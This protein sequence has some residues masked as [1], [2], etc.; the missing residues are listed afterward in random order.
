MRVDGRGWVKPE[1]Y[2]FVMVEAG[3]GVKLTVL[4]LHP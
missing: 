1:H 2:S 4:G 3:M